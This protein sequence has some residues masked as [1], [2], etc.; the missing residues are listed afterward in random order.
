MVL[1]YAHEVD[2]GGTFNHSRSIFEMNRLNRLY[3]NTQSILLFG[4]IILILSFTQ[5]SH[6]GE[7]YP[8]CG[9]ARN[10]QIAIDNANTN[11][12]DDYIGL[13]GEGCIYD[14]EKTLVIK[15]DGGGWNNWV[16]ID[17]NGAII[18][19]VNNVRVFSVEE[20]AK[21]HLKN[22]IIRH[23]KAEIGGG[24]Y[25]QGRVWLENTTFYENTASFAG[26]AIYSSFSMLFIDRS[27]FEGNTAG[28]YGGAISGDFPWAGSSGNLSIRDSTIS[29]NSAKYGGG[30]AA[31]D[32]DPTIAVRI[33]NSTLHGNVAEAGGNLYLWTKG[34]SIV[35]G[36][37]VSGGTASGDGGGI[38]N[39][40]DSKLEITQTTISNNTSQNANGGGIFNQGRVH[41]NNSTVTGNN[42]DYAGAIFNGANP[43]A[44]LDLQNT[45]VAENQARSG[46][47]GILNEGR[48][49]LRN[50]ILANSIGGDCYSNG[51]FN[52]SYDS[53]IEDGGCGGTLTGDPLLGQLTGSPAYFPLL[54]GSIAIDAGINE[55]GCLPYDQRGSWRPQD[56]NGD[57]IAKCDL[58]AYEADTVPTKTSTHTHT[59]T[60]TKTL[61]PGATATPTKTPSTTKTKTATPTKT[62]AVTPTPTKTLMSGATAT[63][64]NT[65]VLTGTAGAT[66]TPTMT[67]E[68]TMAAS[69]TADATTAVT[70]TAPAPSYTPTATPL[71]EGTELLQNG[72][73]E[74][75]DNNGKIMLSPWTVKDASG[76]KVKCNK[77]DKQVAYNGQCAFQFK[78]N[79]GEKAV[80]EQDIELDT[81]TFVTGETL[82]LNLYINTKN[83]SVSGK[84]KLSVKYTDNLLSP[85]KVSLNLLPTNG[86]E[87][88]TGEVSIKSGDVA[89]IKLAINHKGA[90]GKVFVD[91]VSLR[92][93]EVTPLL[94]LP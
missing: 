36:S 24:I 7:H 40:D 22:V 2:R 44:F 34:G 92:Q 12:E 14:L 5:M 46:T 11:G 26:G 56:G 90:S 21:L 48:L 32:V 30:V 6:A 91:S 25:N 35:N 27:T 66:T 43:N 9:N 61:I 72:N 52:P 57:G 75:T 59:S 15:A 58:G 47:G 49:N 53:L 65:L 89:K 81:T 71:L 8:A 80:L 41:L 37:T 82:K 17:G 13:A 88:F 86:Y 51:T 94:A 39:R 68:G 20:G 70:S 74:Q 67:L 45:T 28:E 64:T 42:A 4:V 55:I 19:G 33:D 84:V 50:S 77:S 31:F 73:F 79:E 93:L 54:P 18:S 38:Y 83:P 87:A 10:L 16:T 85:D 76:D 29:Y 1:P 60:A 63:P 23:G 3:N 62:L 78:G 69:P